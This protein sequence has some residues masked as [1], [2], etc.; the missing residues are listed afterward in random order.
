MAGVTG[1]TGKV[2]AQTLLDAGQ[3]VRVVVRDAAKGAPWAA[4]GAEV[5]VADLG[6]A[7]ALTNALRGATSAYLLLPPNATSGDF[8]AYQR[9]TGA[10]L[11]AAVKESGLGQVVLLS[12]VGAQHAAGTGPIAGL[13]PVEQGLK[14]L[15]VGVTAVRAAYFMENFGGSL[16][17]LPQ[18]VLP[19]FTP[20]DFAFD[21]IATRDIG[22]VAAKALREGAKGFEV[23]E[24]S[25]ARRYS[26][27]DAA[28]ALTEITGKTVT[29]QQF[30]LDAMVPTLTGFGFPP[31]I[32]A[33]YHEMT[34]GLIRGHVA[35]E[36]APPG[37][38]RRHRPRDRAPRHHQ[39]LTT[40]RAFP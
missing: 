24:L 40:S 12:S 18:G 36:G 20:T 38:R 4:K 11:L 39:A 9:R 33:L 17:M 35:F 10:S 34:D 14:A 6:D 8:R 30:P 29:A 19:S 1:N 22:L 25:A 27:N 32:A 7:A 26:P 31:D 13:H 15:G 2:A 23:V 37:A 28:A 5:A 3:K 21:M 16:A